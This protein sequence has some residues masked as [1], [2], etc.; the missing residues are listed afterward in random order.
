GFVMQRSIDLAS[1]RNELFTSPHGAAY[2]WRRR[3]GQTT[4][5]A[6]VSDAR[7]DGSALLQRIIED[8]RTRGQTSLT[9]KCPAGLAAN[10]WYRRRGFVLDHTEPGKAR[11]LN[12]WRYA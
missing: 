6:I 1:V 12:V 4:I 10:D 3:D 8:S 9:A 5:H 11:S 2:V 7:G